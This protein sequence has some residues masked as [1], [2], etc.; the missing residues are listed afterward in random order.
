MD[1]FMVVLEVIVVL[2][3]IFMGARLGGIA[4]GAMGGVGL[5]VLTFI[6]HLKPASPPID[7]ILI[8]AAVITAAGAMQTAGGLDYLVGVAEK[9]LRKHPSRITYLGPVVTWVFTFLA[10][11]GHVAYSVM[12]V[13]AE[14][15]REAGVRPERPMS[16]AAIA[17]QQAITCS[18]VSAATAAMIGILASPSIVG[19]GYNLGLI[20]I[21][22][23]CVPA[24][25]IGCMVAA[26]VMNHIGK[27][28]KDDP[29]Y[30]RRVKEGLIPAQSTTQVERKY[31]PFARRSVGI[32][33]LGAVGVVSVGLIRKFVPQILPEGMSTP[34]AIEIVMLTVAG[35]IIIFCKVNVS[36]VMGG[37]VFQAGMM[38]VIGIFGIAWMG[39][40]FFAAHKTALIANLS[41]IASSAPWIFAIALF[42]LSVLLYSQAATT[43][44]LMPVG[45]TL[46]IPAPF[47]IAM[48]PSVNGYFFIPNYPTIVA[49]IGFDRTGTTGIGRFVLN[50]SF[51]LPG[52]IATIC[53]VSVGFAI[54]LLFLL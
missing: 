15:S 17:S 25:F 31:E 6:F 32:F 51:M 54:S 22:A 1:I 33:L 16:I 46:G 18:P 38:A 30:L 43:S 7:V 45:V 26:F 12:P 42:F 5:F 50:H 48:F 44:A 4:L 13:I 14:V 3:A 35:L 49:A 34:Q 11:T 53:A 40:T 2:L 41:G 9:I 29:E 21:I 8:I 47:L 24:T 37:N 23:I 52:L 19:L 10:G 36:K 27:E 28:L 39:D 20:E